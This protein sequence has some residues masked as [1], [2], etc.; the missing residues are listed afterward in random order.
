MFYHC[1]KTGIWNVRHP[2]SDFHFA[3]CKQTDLNKHASLSL[4]LKWEDNNV[5]LH[6]TGTCPLQIET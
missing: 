2:A 1:L 4:Y 5:C 6:I 3:G